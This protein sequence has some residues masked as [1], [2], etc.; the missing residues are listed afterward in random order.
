M[1]VDL[2]TKRPILYDHVANVFPGGVR[3]YQA[4]VWW[5][6]EGRWHGIGAV[7]TFWQLQKFIDL[8]MNRWELSESQAG[9]KTFFNPELTVEGQ[10]NPRLDVNSPG[11]L[12]KRD[13]NMPASRILERVPL[14]EFKGQNLDALIDRATQIFVNM[15]G[16][17]NGNDA[18]A[19]G[20]D[21]SQLATGINNIAQSGEEM[22]TPL[23]VN[24]EDGITT[25]ATQCLIIAVEHMDDEEAFAVVGPNGLA[26]LKKLRS[27][28]IRNLQWNVSLEVS[29]NRSQRDVAQLSAAKSAAVEY[30][31]L[32]PPNQATLA[33]LYRQLLKLYGVRD[34]DKILPLPAQQAV[35]DHSAAQQQPQP[36]QQAA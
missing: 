14:H 5:P 15:S 11:Y 20:L 35:D 27:S 6:V 2:D 21:T 10:N 9:S 26:A 1:V 29:S 32:P 23:L 13:V 7:E 30:L 33:P 31:G 4:I 12:R 24:L 16:V 3:P 28:D 8:C 36:A 22:F 19:A 18:A 25:V 17:S 34:V